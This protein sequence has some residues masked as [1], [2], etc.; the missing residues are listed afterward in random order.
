M[1]TKQWQTLLSFYP[2]SIIK[3][4]I[5]GKRTYCNTFRAEGKKTLMTA[6]A[7]AILDSYFCSNFEIELNG[8]FMV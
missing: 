4:E 8:F 3:K 2:A 1:M 7:F 5:D 6:L